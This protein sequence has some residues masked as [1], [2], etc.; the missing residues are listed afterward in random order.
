VALVGEAGG[1]RDF[2][3]GSIGSGDLLANKIEAKFA[4][5]VAHGASTVTPEHARQVERMDAGV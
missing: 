4:N 5:V 1:Q 2:D 3:K